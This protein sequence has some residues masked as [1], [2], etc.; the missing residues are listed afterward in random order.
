MH[1]E[2]IK[3]LL[4]H[5]E[6]EIASLHEQA[7]KE[8]ISKVS[9]KNTLENLRSVLDYSAQDILERL[10][11]SSNNNKLPT[12][13]YFPYGQKENH[14]KRSI[15]N[16]LPNLKQCEPKIHNLLEN[17]QPFKLKDNWLVDLCSLTNDVKHNNLTKTTNNKSFTVKQGGIPLVEVGHGTKLTMTGTKVNGVLQDDVQI[18]PNGDITVKKISGQTEITS[19]N[20]IKF[21]G[22]ELEVVPFLKKCHDK[23]NTLTTELGELLN[24]QA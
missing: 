5:C 1:N 17:S 23:L 10:K 13:V 16:N 15:K 8:N 12:K 2:D 18:N 20:R 14:F 11:E 4:D 21:D 6:K 7:K 22:K 24:E 3:E 9:V 19:N